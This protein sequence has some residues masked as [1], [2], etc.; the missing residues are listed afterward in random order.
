MNEIFE[1]IAGIFEELR[2]ESDDREYTVRTEK[3]KTASREL[4]KRQKAFEA[5]LS[6]LS[7]EDRELLEDYIDALDHAH[8]QEEQ[9][10]Y[11]QGI[12]DSVQV[13]DGLGI[14]K[15][16]LDVKELLKKYTKQ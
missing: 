2:S 5:Y 9:R 8:Y 12:V 15:K 11:Y 7:K 14:I 10:A 16:R 4:K 6:C 1:T 3:A 13:L